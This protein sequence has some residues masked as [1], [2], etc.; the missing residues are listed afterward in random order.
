MQ[1]CQ[2]IPQA[3]R[4]DSVSDV[5]DV[6]YDMRLSDQTRAEDRAVLLRLY[7]GQPPFSEA[8]AEE[9]NIQVNMNDLTGPNVLA[10]AR[11]QW[12]GA[13][14]KP[15][16]FF[17]AKPDAGPGHKRSEWASAFS[18]R[19][20]R[21][22][23]RD[24]RMVGLVRSQGANTMLFGIGPSNWKDRRTIIPNPIPVGSLLIP[25]ETEID[26]WGNLQYFAIFREW[27][28]AMLWDMTHGPKTDPGWNMPLV[29]AQFDY[30]KDEL[31]KSV[32]SL[33]YEFMADRIE[34]LM[35]QSKGYLGSDAVPTCDVYDFYFREAEDGN[36]WYRR[37]ILDWGNGQDL[38]G[39]KKDG[40]RPE[41]R[42]KV[43]EKSGFLYTSGKR[44]V[45]RIRIGNHSLP[46]R[47]LLG[48]RAVQVP[49]RTRTGLDDVGGVRASEP[50]P[51]QIQRSGYGEA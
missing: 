37:V 17:S 10:Q 29:S 49:F 5:E 51:L 3:M 8:T 47:G 9:Q 43:G 22:I 12:N 34:E 40:P 44:K 31:R 24:R 13:H 38:T 32:N 21:L 7:N 18:S 33:A 11:A 19:S 23:K 45:R 42:N 26:D 41:S 27:T 16:N 15:S 4:F 30:I 46:V 35:K 28:P 48:L 50:A 2:L 20:N 25:S 36:G 1:P 14:L 39:Y 6:V